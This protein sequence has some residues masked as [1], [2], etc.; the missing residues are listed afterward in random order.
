M[1]RET[2]KRQYETAALDALIVAAMT[3]REHPLGG[4]SQEDGEQHLTRE[5]REFLA[6]LPSDIGRLV[7]RDGWAPEMSRTDSRSA[8]T[9]HNDAGPSA[10]A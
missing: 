7:A 1:R 8:S 2:R 6:S 5:D 3:L 4:A 10:I 9:T